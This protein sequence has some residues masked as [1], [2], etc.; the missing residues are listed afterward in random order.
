MTLSNMDDEG[1]TVEIEALDSLSDFYKTWLRISTQERAAIEA[2]IHRRVD[3]L[4]N[5]PNPRWGAILNT[6]IEGNKDHS[7]TDAS[8]DWSST[9][10]HP[11]YVA[12]SYSE[13]RAGLFFST[14]WKKLIIERPEKWVSMRSDPARSEIPEKGILLAGKRYF[15]V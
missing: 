10:F 2:E 6:S 11:I 7:Q 8:G 3:E 13:Q 14:L 9:V 15:P 5:S 1:C 4:I 12:C